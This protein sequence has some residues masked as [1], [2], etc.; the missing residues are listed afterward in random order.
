MSEFDEEPTIPGAQVVRLNLAGT[1]VFLIALAVAIPFRNHRFAQF[2][3][4]GVSMALFAIGVATTLW[5]YTRALD[6]SRVEEVGVANL[7]LLTG[8]TAPK[9][10]RRTMS[11]ALTVQIVAALAGAWI[12]VVGLDEGQLNALGLRG[13]G[14]DVRSRDERGVGVRRTARTDHELAKW[15]HR[16]ITRSTRTEQWLKRRHRRQPLRLHLIACGRSPPTSS[17]TRNGQRT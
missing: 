3:I 1:A 14:A 16:Q 4:A 7:Y 11:L 10:V 8:D 12:G 15:C 9:P 2:L 17:T 13:S 6:R 5:A